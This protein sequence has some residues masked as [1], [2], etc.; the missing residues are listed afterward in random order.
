M[1]QPPGHALRLAVGRRRRSRR[2]HAKSHSPMHA[3]APAHFARDST[4]LLPHSC[5]EPNDFASSVI[6]K[7]EVEARGSGTQEARDSYDP[8]RPLL[9]E[10]RV[11]FTGALGGFER[12]VFTWELIG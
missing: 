5:A 3:A 7:E 11:F 8:S 4:I 12:V 2:R 6:T 1:L 10:L 9:S